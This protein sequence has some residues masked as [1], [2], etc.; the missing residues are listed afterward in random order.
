[1]LKF[2]KGE[3]T[4]RIG[5]L[6]TDSVLPELSP[7]F[8]DYPD[9]F[10]ALLRTADP[11]LEFRVWDMVAHER[12]EN[13][14]ICDGWLITGSRHSVYEDLPWIRAL[15]ELVREIHTSR[16]KLLAICFGHQ[17]VGQ[18]LGGQ[19][20]PAPHGWTVGLQT[21]HRA[22]KLPEKRVFP[23]SL[24][25]IHSHQDQ[26]LELPEKAELLA[27]NEACP[28]GLFQI[29]RHILAMQGHPEFRPPY[30]DALYAKRRALLGETT[31]A[32]AT[33]SL[34]RSDDAS[35]I[36]RLMVDFVKNP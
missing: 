3:Q 30:A 21:M 9:M 14:D 29:G 26:V 15:E 7:Q 11:T 4:M 35:T 2:G 34:Q 22:E 17:L 6:K 32:A 18:V 36:A 8:G 25:L 27:G 20:G 13:L 12:P 28:F 24:R 5:I 23:Q 19:T 16:R 31:Y 1:M 10:S 33:E